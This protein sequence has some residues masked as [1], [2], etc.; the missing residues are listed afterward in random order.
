MPIYAIAVFIK[1]G[2]DK[3][4]LCLT[5]GATIYFLRGKGMEIGRDLQYSTQGQTAKTEIST[6][7]QLGERERRNRVTV[8]RANV[9][10]TE[11]ADMTGEDTAR[12]R[13]RHKR[14]K[15]VC[16]LGVFSCMDGIT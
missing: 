6:K 10:A 11:V 7:K 14:P 8:D 1:N 2:G 9:Q 15:Q 16:R 3:E 5:V 4:A 12:R 13:R